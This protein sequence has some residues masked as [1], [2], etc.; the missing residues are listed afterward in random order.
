[1]SQKVEK[2]Q[3]DPLLFSAENQKVPKI[4]KVPNFKFFPI[5]SE[6]FVKKMLVEL[7]KSYGI[8]EQLIDAHTHTHKEKENTTSAK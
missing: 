2:V 6:G 7:R 3:K 1:M 5:R 8:L 4:Q